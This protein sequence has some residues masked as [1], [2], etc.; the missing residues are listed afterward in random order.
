PVQVRA[1][2]L[3]ATRPRPTGSTGARPTGSVPL[4][5]HHADPGAGGLDLG[6]A[7]LPGALA[8]AAEDEQVAGPGHVPQRAAAALGPQQEAPRAAEGH[9][10]HDRLVGAPPDAVAVPGHA[11]AAVAVE[12]GGHDRELVLVALG[13]HAAQLGDRGG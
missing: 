8:G 5:E 10:R 7:V 13:Q 12:T 3:A 6:H 2:G 4:P 9:Q 1:A 11:V